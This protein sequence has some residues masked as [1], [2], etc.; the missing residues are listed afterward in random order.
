MLKH[1]LQSVLLLGLLLLTA[2]QVMELVSHDS[3]PGG[4]VRAW[5]EPGDDL[6]SLTAATS[7]GQSVSLATGDTVI[8]L[9]FDPHCGHSLEVAPVWRDWI[10]A[11]EASYRLIGISSGDLTEAEAF[12]RDQAWEMEIGTVS[13]LNGSL[14]H[15]LTVR[16]PWAFI[17]DEA[18]QV[19]AEGIGSRIG[20]LL[21]EGRGQTRMEGP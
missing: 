8:V 19:V 12:A 18:G 9:V 21:P 16:T 17:L 20:E 5:L 10:S 4:L 6:S 2:V 11:H 14:G 3:E 15:A 1:P 13:A 7:A